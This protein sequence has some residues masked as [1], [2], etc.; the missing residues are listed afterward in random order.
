MSGKARPSLRAKTLLNVDYSNLSI[1]DKKCIHEVFGHYEN[2]WINIEN[3]QPEPFVSVLGYMTDAGHFPPVRECYMLNNENFFFPALN[4]H[5][6]ISHW[7]P[8]PE[9]PKGDDPK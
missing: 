1:T 6:P 5:H 3:Q 2:Q 8:M 9:P 4:E 7:M